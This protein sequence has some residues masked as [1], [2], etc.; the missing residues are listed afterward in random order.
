MGWRWEVR[1]WSSGLLSSALGFLLASA[2]SEESLGPA[3]IATAVI[4]GAVLT[5]GGVIGPLL[6]LKAMAS[7]YQSFDFGLLSKGAAWL[8]AAKSADSVTKGAKIA[9]GVGLVLSIGIAWGIFIYAVSS[10]DISAGTWLSAPYWP[11][12]SPRRFWPLSL[13]PQFFSGRHD[14]RGHLCYYRSTA[15]PA[16][17]RL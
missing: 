11:R 1:F 13:R 2:L 3:R 8:K 12:L 9:A 4:V 16:G 6:Q 7:L 14:H 5:Y 15:F 17:R 10:G